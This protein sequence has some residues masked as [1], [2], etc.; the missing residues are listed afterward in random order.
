[1]RLRIHQSPTR[2]L[3]ESPASRTLATAAMRQGVRRWFLRIRSVTFINFRQG[4]YG[5][6]STLLALVLPVL[7]SRIAV[8]NGVV[9]FSID[10]F[11]DEGG[12]G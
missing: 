7:D 6:F 11:D 3:S 12:D 5:P 9:I 8:V 10:R 1:M 2:G 4:I